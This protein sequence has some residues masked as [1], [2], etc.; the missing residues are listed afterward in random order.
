MTD[1][2]L[3]EVERALCC[4]GNCRALAAGDI[5]ACG[6]SQTK[7]HAALAIMVVQCAYRDKLRALVAVRD[8]A[9]KWADWFADCDS[10][11]D[12]C[13]ANFRHLAKLAS[14]ALT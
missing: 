3:H 7:Q 1:T 9:G 4:L 2:L 10:P 14:D 8:Q 12:E 13:A 5:K 6:A 11:G